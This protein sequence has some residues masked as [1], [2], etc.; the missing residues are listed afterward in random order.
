MPRSSA[1]HRFPFFYVLHL[2]V[3]LAVALCVSGWYISPTVHW[4]PAVMALGFAFGW[5]FI[6]LCIYYGF[7]QKKKFFLLASVVIAL[8][9][10]PPALSTY[11][12][13]REHPLAPSAAPSHFRLMQWNVQELSGNYLLDSSMHLE[14][15]EALRFLLT[16]RPHV[17]CVQD[18]SQTDGPYTT[19]NL[20]ML[21]DTAGFIH[22]HVVYHSSSLYS[23]GKFRQGIG[24][25]SRLPIVRKGYE[26]YLDRDLPEHIV[27]ADVEWQGRLLRV[28]TTHFRSINLNGHKV[29]TLG[30]VPLFQRQDAVLIAS[31]NRLKKLQFYQLEHARQAALLK[32]FLD[33]CSVPVLLAADLNTVPAS[34]TY[35]MAK[36][37]LQDSY[38]GTATG[39][40]ATF[41]YLAPQLRI[42]YIFHHPSFQKEHF[43]HYR[44]GFFDH[45]HLM[46]DY[47]WRQ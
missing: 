44:H 26:A 23:Y 24:I 12:I 17:V 46:G 8:L 9:G 10:L 47:S 41:N 36:A 25:F 3:L 14:R 32:G 21:R 35:R 16:H 42:D 34:H 27:W 29:F 4:L 7:R 19:S 43:H 15:L 20:K 22:Q 38:P 2:L 18:F 6:F 45:D 13:G 40:G 37:N 1:N 5:P 31:P 28:V 33:T 39:L 11:S 30:S